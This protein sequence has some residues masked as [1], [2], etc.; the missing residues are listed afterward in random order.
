LSKEPEGGVLEREEVLIYP[1]TAL[2]ASKP[3]KETPEIIRDHSLL[4]I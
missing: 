3:L 2:L 4:S 1:T